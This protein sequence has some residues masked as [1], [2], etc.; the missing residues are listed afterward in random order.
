ML[1]P[2]VTTCAFSL[3]VTAVLLALLPAHLP[4]HLFVAPVTARS[5]HRHHARQIGGI[6]AAPAIFVAIVTSGLLFSIP[7]SPAVLA[8]FALLWATGV[9]DD[10]R[11]LPA[12]PK[13]GLQLVGAAI[14]AWGIADGQPMLGLIFALIVLWLVGFTNVVNFMDGLDLMT[15]AGLLPGLAFVAVLP[16][17][18]SAD[19]AS[20]LLGAAGAGAAPSVA[21]SAA[22][23]ASSL[24]R[25]S[26]R[27]AKMARALASAAAASS[28][29]PSTR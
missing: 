13:L 8:A 14:A 10:I 5:N 29:R 28:V 7:V 3:V 20:G 15:V 25:S 9:V 1:L 21:V 18:S 12:L 27:A 6:A 11:D 17:V 4:P 19:P 22:R 26:G 16:I 2:M 24:A 23:E